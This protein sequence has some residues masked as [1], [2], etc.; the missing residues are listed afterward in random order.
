MKR[1]L[2]A[3]AIFSL[4]LLTLATLIS[5]PVLAAEND[6]SYY[7]Q[8]PMETGPEVTVQC[9]KCHEKHAEDF[10]K[11]THWTW[12][13][14]QL[15][16]DKNVVRG[17]KNAINNFCT[18][19]AGNWPRCTSCHAGYGWTDNN[20]DFTNAANVDC[21]VCHDTTGTYVKEPTGAGNPAKRVDLVYVAQSVGMPS[22]FNCGTCHFYGGGGDAVKRGDLALATAAMLA[23]R[24][25]GSLAVSATACSSRASNAGSWS[26]IAAASRP[27][28]TDAW[29][30][31]SR[32][33]SQSSAISAPAALSS[34]NAPRMP[35]I[36]SAR[37]IDG[38]ATRSQ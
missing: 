6:H 19:I 10:M 23:G 9:L 30:S 5:G 15:V 28:R 20:F 7:V 27:A 25:A 2:L 14:D 33:A 21:L 8:G 31:G 34:W 12:A 38:P 29:S 32:A 36:G 1:Y 3:G 4:L 22:R 26:D 24:W 16:G 37:R 13:Q 35:G 18:S 11:T 17:K